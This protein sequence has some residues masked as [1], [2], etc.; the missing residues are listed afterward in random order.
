[1]CHRRAFCGTAKKDVVAILVA[2]MDC[3]TMLHH[4]V[5]PYDDGRA[6]HACMWSAHIR[7]GQSARRQ[8]DA[9]H[10]PV[11][12][13]ARGAAGMH[14]CARADHYSICQLDPYL[15]GR[16]HRPAHPPLTPV[17]RWRVRPRQSAGEGNGVRLRTPAGGGCGGQRT[18]EQPRP[19]WGWCELSVPF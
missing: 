7:S 14:S 1:M 12:P 9:D 5:G 13:L 18:G 19:T 4:V 2:C 17:P 8:R 11:L 16:A 15:D 3:A 6:M 10:H